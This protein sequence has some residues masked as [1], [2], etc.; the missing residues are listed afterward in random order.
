MLSGQGTQ[1]ASPE[2]RTGGPGRTVLHNHLNLQRNP[3]TPSC[4]GMGSSAPWPCF[5]VLHDHMYA[6]D[7]IKHHSNNFVG[8]LQRKYLVGWA[9]PGQDRGTSLGSWS[10]Q[11]SAHTC[12]EK[13]CTACATSSAVPRPYVQRAYQDP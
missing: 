9:L 11:C 7:C 5:A 3:A 2:Q 8:S 1:E 13:Y 6:A 4:L 12:A 10:L